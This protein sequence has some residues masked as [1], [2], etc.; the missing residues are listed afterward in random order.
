MFTEPVQHVDVITSLSTLVLEKKVDKKGHRMFL[1]T[2]VRDSVRDCDVR[3]LFRKGV[4][5]G[6]P[7]MTTVLESQSSIACH[8]GCSRGAADTRLVSLY[9]HSLQMVRLAAKRSADGI[10]HRFVYVCEVVL[11][12]AKRSADDNGARITID[13]VVVDACG[14]KL[15]IVQNFS[16]AKW[17]G[18][19]SSVG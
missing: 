19:L 1:Q 4:E 18:A 17:L 6:G 10:A 2:H 3:A 9:T 15:L 13:P 7:P 14:N 8:C 16:L 12:A 5:G 11:V